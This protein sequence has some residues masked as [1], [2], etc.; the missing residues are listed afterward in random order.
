M[1]ELI[2]MHNVE[3]KNI[4]TSKLKFCKHIIEFMSV[5]A[6]EA[7]DY[8]ELYLIEF[9]RRNIDIFEVPA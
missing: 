4:K 7:E 1:D 2:A 6:K 3:M 8:S 5:T 9:L